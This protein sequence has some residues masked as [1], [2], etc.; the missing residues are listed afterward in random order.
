MA[1]PTIIGHG[2][3]QDSQTTS[4]A[5]AFPAAYTATAN[6]IVLLVLWARYGGLTVTYPDGTWTE[7]EGSLGGSAGV[8]S[9]RIAWKRLA[10]GES[11]PSFTVAGTTANG[12][13]ARLTIIR[14]C[15]TGAD[16]IE[17]LG[18]ESD[19][20][21]NTNVV[22]YPS[23]NTVTA[24]SLALAVGIFG[25]DSTVWP[26]PTSSGASWALEY[27][28]SSTTGS[29]S[30]GHMASA[31]IASP[32]ATGIA[33]STL[34]TPANTR[35]AGIQLALKPAA[36]GGGTDHT[37]TPAA[38]TATGQTLAPSV[39]VGSNVSLTPSAV[40]ATGATLAPTVT[41]GLTVTPSPA[42]ATGATPVLVPEATYIADAVTATA[43][44]SAPTVTTGSNVTLTPG[45]VTAAGGTNT[46]TVTL[47]ATVAPAAAPA[48]CGTNAPAVQLGLTL[49][50]SAV[51]GT[52]Q[53]LA[54]TVTAGGNVTLTPAAVAATGGTN[55]PTVSAGSTV[56]VAI[57]TAAA[58]TYAPSVS[59]GSDFTYQATAASATAGTTGVTLTISTTGSPDPAGAVAA[60]L[61]PSAGPTLIGRLD[62]GSTI[63]ALDDGGLA[64]TGR[65]D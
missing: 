65:I 52:G 34:T 42:T 37:E 35:S 29:D 64:L 63:S 28:D 9:G 46:P 45:A 5:P 13:W 22:T 19:S 2:A 15:D 32:G 20:G 56:T 8:V 26:T 44:T 17:V 50:P 7:R 38:V 3:L 11:A 58:G 59:A 21:G 14:G 55:S 6:D 30:S 27:Y 60:T 51:T 33:T 49:T 61:A 47:G 57:V 53:T 40:T 12:T 62:G 24:D 1:A 16:P 48:S 18:L 36:G 54:P 23:I 39:S 43:G 41:G 4:I 10:G 31:V 25:N